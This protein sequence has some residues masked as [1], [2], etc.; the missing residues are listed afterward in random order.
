MTE[1]EWNTGIR[2]LTMLEFLRGKA[3][4]RKLRLFACACCRRHRSVLRG[5]K[6]RQMLEVS[7]DFADDRIS[8][9]DMEKMRKRWYTFDYPF[10][11]T[12]TWQ[13]ALA[14][15]TITHLTT[16]A[17]ETATHAAQASNRPERERLVQADVLRDIFGNPFRPVPVDRSILLWHDGAVVHMAQSIYDG[18]RFQDLPIL[19]DAL[20]EA[21]CTDP[22]ILGHCR[23]PGKHVRGC[24]VVDLVLGKL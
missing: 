24:W 1:Q 21:G 7:E 9:E 4:D 23:G 12:G 3:S 2:P 5:K 11:L 18:R 14:C 20:E 13:M 8:R 19:A 16:W 6:S 15:A 22:G 17:T 10:P